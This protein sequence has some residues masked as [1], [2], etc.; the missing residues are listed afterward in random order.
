MKVIIAGSR[1]I[2]NIHLIAKA[3]RDS[4][5]KVTEVVSGTARGVDRLGERWATNNGVPIRRFP[6]DWDTFGKSAGYQRNAEMAMYADALIAIWD[7]YSKGTGHM[8]QLA[9]THHLKV[10]VHTKP[11]R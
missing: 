7:G 11:K 8:I 1:G 10:Y 2:D 4:G 5:F 3:V 6:A 9:N